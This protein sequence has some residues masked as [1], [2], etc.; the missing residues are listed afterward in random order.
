MS[1]VARVML[2]IASAAFV[3][4]SCVVA[5]AVGLSRQPS[6]HPGDMPHLALMLTALAFM[7]GGVT[8][9]ATGRL[10]SARRALRFGS[11][12]ALVLLLG[13]LLWQLP[14][15]LFETHVP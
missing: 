4:G 3:I 15:E 10:V 1:A 5:A 7:L 12:V 8:A 2:G 11:V 9:P 14:D 13:I 6:R